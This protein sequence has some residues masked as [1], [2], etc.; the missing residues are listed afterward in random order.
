MRRDLPLPAWQ[1]AGYPEFHRDRGNLLLHLATA[2]LF[3]GG[4]LAA[5]ASPFVGWWALGGGLGALAIALAAQGR[6]HRREGRPPEP[7]LGPGDFL[8]RLFVEQ[9][10]TFPRFVLS[11]GFARAFNRRPARAA[12]GPVSGDAAGR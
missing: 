3:I 8:G 11:G 4:T 1:W 6:G 7:F 9:F 5:L 12:G 2:P 10:V